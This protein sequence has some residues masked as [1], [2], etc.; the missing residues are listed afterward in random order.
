M[1]DKRHR[2]SASELL[3]TDLD[4]LMERAASRPGVAE[5][6]ALQQRFQ[7]KLAEIDASLGRRSAVTFTTSDSTA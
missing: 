3:A 6:L 4:R 2:K 5:V 1:P 7:A